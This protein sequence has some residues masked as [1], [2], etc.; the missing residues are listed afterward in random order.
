VP[1]G[2]PPPTVPVEHDEE[3][4]HMPFGQQYGW[5]LSQQCPSPQSTG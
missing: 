3:L 2:V 4:E 5:A 1:L